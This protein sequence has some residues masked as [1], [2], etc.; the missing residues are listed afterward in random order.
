MWGRYAHDYILPERALISPPFPLREARGFGIPPRVPRTVRV[1]AWRGGG[2][3]GGGRRSFARTA[4]TGGPV[5]RGLGVPGYTFERT[6]TPNG[7]QATACHDVMIGALDAHRT[8]A[9]I[10]KSQINTVALE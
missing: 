8:R 3:A 1:Q 6:R 4:R 5:E 7:I 9:I 10:S 2:G